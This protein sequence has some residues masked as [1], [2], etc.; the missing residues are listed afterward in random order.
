MNCHEFENLVV[1]L[2]RGVVTDSLVGTRC[3]AHA[4][5]CPSCADRLLDQEK[6]TAGFEALTARA[7]AMPA[8][9]RVEA[10]LRGEFRSHFAKNKWRLASRPPA[11]DHPIRSWTRQ[12]HWAWVG[13]AALLLLSL[14]GFLAAGYR[15][16]LRTADTAQNSAAPKATETLPPI[17]KS[18]SSAAK[19]TREHPSTQGA[20]GN[21][22]PKSNKG[23]GGKN[24]SKTPTRPA[25]RSTK[26][27][28]LATNFYPLPY[29][30][31]LPL[32]EGWEIV[33][34][35]MPRSSLAN[36]GVPLTGDQG[37][38]ASI[39]ADLVLGEDGLARAI[40]FVE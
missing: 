22:V 14:A 7:D 30:S 35:S 5:N 38:T 13:A 36:L 27:D 20:R 24:N 12:G 4:A 39:K 8:Q 37:T 25:F 1:D 3:W 9:E 21:S 6:L 31:G 23:A 28:E 18:N 15:M 34:V 33:R 17:A 32:D 11:W 26:H 10:I 19:G 29:G 40:R 2:A 16:K